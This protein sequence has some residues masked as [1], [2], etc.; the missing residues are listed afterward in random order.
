MNQKARALLRKITFLFILLG[1]IDYVVAYGLPHWA[2]YTT[3]AGQIHRYGLFMTCIQ[4][5]IKSE[6]DT[7]H[8]A[9]IDGKVDLCNAS[10]LS[11]NVT[12]KRCEV[13]VQK[14]HQVGLKFTFRNFYPPPFLS[15]ANVTFY[16]TYKYVHCKKEIVCRALKKTLQQLVLYSSVFAVCVHSFRDWHRNCCQPFP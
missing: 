16:S 13:C 5:F 1:F 3:T 12:K 10:P 4:D 6:C 15:A 2:K 11:G 8:L 7:F 14:W 9:N